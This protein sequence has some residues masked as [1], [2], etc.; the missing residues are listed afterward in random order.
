MLVISANVKVLKDVYICE[1][2]KGSHNN[3]YK[4]RAKGHHSTVCLFR[5]ER[6]SSSHIC[7]F[8]MHTPYVVHHTSYFRATNE[9][10]KVLS[11]VRDV[12]WGQA[13]QVHIHIDFSCH[14]TRYSEDI[15]TAITHVC[16]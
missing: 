14:Y 10:V 5:R 4:S 2:T 6:E 11:E 16:L 13:F 8:F 1:R 9:G 7:Q 12:V 15:H 3:I